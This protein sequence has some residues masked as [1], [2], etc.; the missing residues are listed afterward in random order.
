MF[1]NISSENSAILLKFVIV[2]NIVRINL[3]I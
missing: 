2:D 1:C 3:F